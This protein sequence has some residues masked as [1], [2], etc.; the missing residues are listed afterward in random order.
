MTLSA[1]GLRTWAARLRSGGAPLCIFK[2]T[3]DRLVDTL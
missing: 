3:P 2:G 1:A